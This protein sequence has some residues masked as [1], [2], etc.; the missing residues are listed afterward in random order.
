MLKSLVVNKEILNYLSILE[1]EIQAN[2]MLVAYMLSNNMDTD[3]EAFRAYE[4]AYKE[5]LFKI[6]EVQKEIITEYIP[7]AVRIEKGC[8]SEG[9]KFKC[10]NR[11]TGVITP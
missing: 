3:T 9:C 4:S 1:F 11:E 10:L 7:E 8:G 5:N 6:R 2:R